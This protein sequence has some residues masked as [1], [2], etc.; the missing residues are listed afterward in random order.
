MPLY[1]IKITSTVVCHQVEA[2]TLQEA[3]DYC[4]TDLGTRF[5]EYITVDPTTTII[6]D[7]TP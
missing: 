2:D 1:D 7:V 6:E 5:G 4:V 3:E